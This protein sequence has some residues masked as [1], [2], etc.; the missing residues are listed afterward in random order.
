MR[1]TPSESTLTRLATCARSSSSS[2][3]ACLM[4]SPPSSTTFPTT[5]CA[6]DPAGPPTIS[7]AITTPSHTA[8][9]IR[10]LNRNQFEI[11]FEIE[12]E[13]PFFS[14]RNEQLLLFRHRPPIIMR[15]PLLEPFPQVQLRAQEV[16]RLRR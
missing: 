3:V 4:T 10:I 11:E 7:A 2:T 6:R 9:P 14:W 16:R 5:T 13:L 15:P 12:I 8:L 1:N